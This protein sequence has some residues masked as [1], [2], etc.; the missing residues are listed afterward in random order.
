MAM[1][2][3][4]V[5]P[6][7]LSEEHRSP[8]SWKRANPVGSVSLLSRN[9]ILLGIAG[10]LLLGY[11][12]QQSL[13]NVYVIY[14]DYRYHWTSQTVGLSL[15]LIGIFSGVYGALLVK[16][17]VKWLGERRAMVLGFI[18]GAT[19]MRSLDFRRPACS[20]GA[21]FHF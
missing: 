19:G 17:V 2:G 14:A 1:Y 13:M 5:L 3:L 20:F 6:E 12:A 15:A 7:S 18:G 21:R 10:L 8:F 11:I 9:R 16:P 4:F